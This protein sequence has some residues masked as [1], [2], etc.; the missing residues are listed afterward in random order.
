MAITLSDGSKISAD[1]VELLFDGARGIYIP[2]AFGD[3]VDGANEEQRARWSGIDE[4]DLEILCA[5]P[6]HMWYW[7]AWDNVLHHAVFT[8]VSHTGVAVEWSLHQDGDLFA[9]A[10]EHMSA[11]EK[12]NFEIED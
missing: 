9:L 2:Q 7:E 10:Y 12:Q 6:D 3:M 5:G 8:L 1:A 4:D 11:E